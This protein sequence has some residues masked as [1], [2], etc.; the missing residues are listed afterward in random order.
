[1]AESGSVLLALLWLVVCASAALLLS[2]AACQRLLRTR[3]FLGTP[4]PLRSA[5]F[6]SAPAGFIGVAAAAGFHPSLSDS[7]SFLMVVP[8]SAGCGL[9]WG[10]YFATSSKAAPRACSW[11]QRAAVGG[12]LGAVLTVAG[13]IFANSFFASLSGKAQ[14]PSLLQTLPLFVWLIP[15]LAIVGALT[16]RAVVSPNH[17]IEATS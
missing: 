15:L 10:T 3:W 11:S 17:S 9:L 8:A 1:M 12:I 4:V 14:G 16:P 13:G 7:A 2:Y 5:V 6:W